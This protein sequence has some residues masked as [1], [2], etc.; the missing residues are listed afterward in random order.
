MRGVIVGNELNFKTGGVRNESGVV[1]GAACVWVE[2]GEEERPT[3]SER[4]R[5]ELLALVNGSTMERE[6]VKA[7]SQPI[8]SALTECGG[9]F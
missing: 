5:N 2:V 4:V 7:W 3:V 8:V 1:I 6:V 9:L